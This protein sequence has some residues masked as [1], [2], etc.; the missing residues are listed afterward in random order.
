MISTANS[1]TN[2]LNEEKVIG[3]ATNPNPNPNK[4]EKRRPRVSICSSSYW[5]DDD[6]YIKSKKKRRV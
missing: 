5:Y 2:I 4:N 6:T 1:W 3:K